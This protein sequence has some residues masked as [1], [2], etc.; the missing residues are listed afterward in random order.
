M[1]RFEYLKA[2]TLE[3]ALSF[4]AMQR[5]AA[6]LLA[7]GTDLIAEL[8]EGL[9]APGYL[10]DIKAL[11]GLDTISYDEQGLTLGALTSIRAIE[12]SS[13][14]QGSRP[15]GV[16]A[17]AAGTLGSVQ[18]RNRATIGGNLCHASPS[19][20]MAPALLALVA[21]LRLQ[22]PAGVRWAS[23]AEF[24]TGPG[25]TVVRADEILTEV[26][27]PKPTGS[28]TGG[29]YIKHS[30]R[31]AMDL[32]VVGVAAVIFISDD[33][34][35][36][37]DIRIGLGGVAP[38]P[39]RATQA[40]GV[41]RGRKLDDGLI[42]SASKMAADDSSPISDVRASAEYRIAMVKVLT[43]RAIRQAWAAAES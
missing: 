15:L 16:L 22:S 31:G 30:P 6:R 7:G 43:N 37:G 40:E 28:R 41:L 4:L 32:A 3:Q 25:E 17:Q 27:V 2:T 29:A 26:R 14:I 1:Q 24:F 11:P 21:T 13:L 33:D 34:A 39:V 42:E 5:G 9:V 23:I 12:T 10:V 38:T 35:T 8:K 36:C 19:A 20:D 18:V